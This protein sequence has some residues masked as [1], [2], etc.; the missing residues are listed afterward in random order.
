[1][2]DLRVE[3]LHSYVPVSLKY[4]DGQRKPIKFYGN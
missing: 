3:A 4:K 1:M 2:F